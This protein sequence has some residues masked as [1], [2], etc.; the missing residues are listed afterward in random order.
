MGWGV[1]GATRGQCQTRGRKRLLSFLLNAFLEK[2]RSWQG[3]LVS[4]V[5]PTHYK[6]TGHVSPAFSIRKFRSGGDPCTPTM[7]HATAPLC[8]GK[9]QGERLITGPPFLKR[10]T[11][12]NELGFC[13]FF[14]SSLIQ[15]VGGHNKGRGLPS[16]TQFKM[17]HYFILYLF[18]G[19][20]SAQRFLPQVLLPLDLGRGKRWLRRW[21]KKIP[22]RRDQGQGR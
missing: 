6:G 9:V 2:Q 15:E 7:L 13:F 5:S 1:R 21:E 22:D 8:K 12:E 19:I 16:V 14:P 18:P 17:C 10:A 11:C 20:P 3:A 4:T